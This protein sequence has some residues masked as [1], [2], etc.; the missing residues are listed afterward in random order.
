M[1][2]DGVVIRQLEGCA[3][4]PNLLWDSVWNPA[5]GLADWALADADEAANVGGLRSKAA[6]DTA[7]LLCLFTD[8]R[9]E[10]DHP[11]WFLADGDRRGYW[12]DGI[13]VR[14][15]EGE[16]P[17]G[18]Y[19]WLLERAPMTIKG[20][21]AGTWAEQF[22]NEALQTLLA[23]EVCARIDVSSLVDEAAGKLYLIV[24]LFASDGSKTYDRQFDVL[25]KQVAL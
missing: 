2:G 20:L 1:M 10:P 25:W 11:L 22:A 7:V 5:R 9:I 8:K 4:N 12:G 19:L 21:S 6:I 17:L 24:Q 3:D 18:S 13:D 15:D 23:Q 14:A 16:G